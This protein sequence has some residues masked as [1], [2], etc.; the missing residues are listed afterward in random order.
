MEDKYL[1]DFIVVACSGGTHAGQTANAI[2]ADMARGG[3]ARMVCLAGVGCEVPESIKEAG[4]VENLIV[5]D[6]CEKGCAV[7]MLAKA[8]IEAKHVFVLTDMG[9]VNSDSPDTDEDITAE[10]RK[11]IKRIFGQVKAGGY[12][13]DSCT[14]T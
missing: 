7:K 13:P 14:D 8:G 6:G 10:L 11:K 12:R 3:F 2:A 9:L 4:K 5:I 1:T